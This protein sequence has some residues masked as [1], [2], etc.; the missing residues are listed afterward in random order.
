MKKTLKRI[1]PVQFGK[2]AGAVYAL[3]SLIFVPFF[4]LFAVLSSLFSH[5]PSAPSPAIMVIGSLIGAIFVP[6]IYGAMGFIFGALG[7]WGYNLISTW[8]GGIEVEV[9]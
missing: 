3:I 4:I 7:A 9:E 6:I 5:E 2:V 1:A 8:V